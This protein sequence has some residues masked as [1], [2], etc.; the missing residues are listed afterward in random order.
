MEGKV[1]TKDIRQLYITAI[2]VSID[3]IL[4]D[5][6]DLEL[7]AMGG[8]VGNAAAESARKRK[9][10]AERQEMVQEQ[11]RYRNLSTLNARLVPPPTQMDTQ[12]RA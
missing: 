8:I 9:D 6:D 4:E 2:K 1:I 11:E 7:F 10:K 12:I 3:Y 5:I